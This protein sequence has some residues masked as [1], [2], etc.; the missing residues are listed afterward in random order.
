MNE[1]AKS[2]AVP[3]ERRFNRQ[4]GQDALISIR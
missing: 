3:W 4:I 1:W 2:A